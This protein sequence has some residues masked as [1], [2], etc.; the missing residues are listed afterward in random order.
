[1]T[2]LSPNHLIRGSAPPALTFVNEKNEVYNSYAHNRSNKW[3][4]WPNG[5]RNGN[6]YTRVEI[7]KEAFKGVPKNRRIFLSF[8]ADIDPHMP[9]A[10]LVLYYKSRR[11]SIDTGSKNFAKALM[12]A[13][14]AGA[15]SRG[16]NL[17]VLRHN[18]A[19]LKLLLELRNLAY[20]DHA[21]ALRYEELRHR[22]AEKVV[23]G[24][25][26]YVRSKS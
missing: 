3:K 17:G 5:G 24:I 19:P 2:L 18:P 10:P 4:D 25:L 8:H 23:K 11:G 13:L 16:Q 26:E 9:E 14:G 15:Y 7:S 1:M 21:W 20:T 12:P 6:L 22:D